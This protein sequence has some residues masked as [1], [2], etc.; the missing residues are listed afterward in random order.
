VPSAGTHHAPGRTEL[1]IHEGLVQLEVDAAV[2]GEAATPFVSL[3][4][5]FEVGEYAPMML[6]FA[7]DEL[8]E[9]AAAFAKAAPVAWGD[10]PFPPCAS[11]AEVRE[12]LLLLIDVRRA[13]AALRAALGGLE[14]AAR[15][16]DD[17]AYRTLEKVVEAFNTTP[18]FD[19]DGGAA[20]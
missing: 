10:Q 2:V 17:H 13:T 11:V 4:M 6:L 5:R 12:R 18:D 9:L 20:G 7:G 3:G 14:A 16:G 15:S 19:F 1:A 8:A